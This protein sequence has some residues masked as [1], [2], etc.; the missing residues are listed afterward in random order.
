MG[1]TDSP[2][3]RLNRDVLEW[4]AWRLVVDATAAYVGNGPALAEEERREVRSVA[5]RHQKDEA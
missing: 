5:R 1:L 2:A 4:P 3:P